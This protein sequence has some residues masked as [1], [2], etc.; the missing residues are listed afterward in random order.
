MSAPACTVAGCGGQ[1]LA[2]GYCNTCGNKAHAAAPATAPV[3]A[4]PSAAPATA[5]PAAQPGASCTQAGCTGTVAAD[6][7]CDTCGIAAASGG[8]HQH[9]TGAPTPS[10]GGTPGSGPAAVTSSLAAP[11]APGTSARL[12]ASGSGATTSRRTS[13]SRRTGATRTAIGAGLVTIAATPEGNPA[14]AVM[15]EAKIQSV[16][17][18]VPEEDRNCTTCGQPVGRS[19]ADRAGR[20][21]GFCGNC[22]TPFDFTTNAP[23]LTAGD[24]VGGQ[25]E[26]LGPLAHGGM[27]WIYLGKDKAVSDR[28]VVLKGLLNSD[29]PDAAAAAVAERQFLAQIEHGSIVNIY[30]FVTWGGAGYIVM[31]FVGGESLNSK[32]KDR[33]KAN[34]GTPD[35]LPVAE[36]IAYILGIL[37]A[38]EYLHSLGLVYNDLK[39]AN[40][41]SVGTGVKLIDVGAVMRAADPDAAIFGTKGFQAP[42]IATM[43]PS[44]SSDLFTVGR[45]LAVMILNFIFH[46]G[47]YEYAL[48]TPAEEV[49]FARWESLYRFLLKATA[50]HPDDR[51]QTADEM[52]EQLTGVLREI[53]AVS[54][55]SPRPV[56]SELFGTDRLASLLVDADD[57]L[58]V[59]EPDAQVLP[60]PKVD[61]ADPAAS[62]V[63]DLADVAPDQA[64]ARI[65]AALG[66]NTVG[67]SRELRFR[68]LQALS[69]SGADVS[70]SLTTLEAQDPWDW[71]VSWHRGLDALRR[72]QPVE[73]AESFSR[74]WTDLP[75]EVAPKL[76]VAVA[77]E[78]A[79]E[80]PRAAQLYELVA[81]IDST[82]VSASF[83]LARCRARTGDRQ[84]AV[85]AYQG[86]PASSA[87]YLDAQVESARALAGAHGS[88]V[89]TAVEL[90][91]AAST[92]ERLQLDGAE[93]ANLAAEI[94]ERALEATEAGQLAP[95]ANTMLFGQP[96]TAKELRRQ[97]ERTYRE[98]ARIAVDPADKVRFVD[99]ANEIRPRSW[100]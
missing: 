96:L 68:R 79:G 54:E 6:G 24:L 71:R 74:V 20:V 55:R 3:A 57:N 40:I 32:L 78:Q 83:G 22:R 92:V 42:E 91:N 28:W 49:L 61:P 85:D 62:F 45:T 13:T 14:E 12:G 16:L 81:S 89:P 65:D 17:G 26:I 72:R 25:Y 10:S 8:A 64:I 52:A 97:L 75:G 31:E 80:Y 23:T 5:R 4:A 9:S 11:V 76:A 90:S 33:R 77:A 34:G 50:P 7:Y 19:N 21:K 66:E 15:S 47:P 38:F 69:E 100:V 99:K 70:A 88:D 29:D 98:Q 95:D 84:G 67:D 1:I 53:V 58:L 51:F 39:P 41:M 73:A 86:V 35:P 2:D 44:V 18:T 63:L 48:P 37:P 43:G 36:A 60:I 93:R 87:T 46:S 94:L 59:I 30:N 82:F 27:G 56:P